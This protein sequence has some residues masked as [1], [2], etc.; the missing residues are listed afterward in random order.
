MSFDKLLSGAHVYPSK[1][2]K[3]IIDKRFINAETF[4]Y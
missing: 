2:E 1:Y 3:V 4:E